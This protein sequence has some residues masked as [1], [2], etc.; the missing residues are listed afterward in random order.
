MNGYLSPK[1]KNTLYVPDDCCFLRFSPADPDHSVDGYKT[2]RK[3]GLIIHMNKNNHVV[4]IELTGS[5]KLC[6]DAPQAQI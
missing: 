2:T 4:A 5:K 3:E 6:Q 1:G